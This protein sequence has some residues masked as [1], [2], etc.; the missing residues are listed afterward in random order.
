MS[1]IGE[2]AGNRGGDPVETISLKFQQTLPPMV[3][4]GRKRMQSIV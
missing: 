4:D 3:C 2:R 1:S